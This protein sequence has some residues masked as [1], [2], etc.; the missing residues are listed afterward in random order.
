MNLR[1]LLV[2]FGSLLALDFTS[3]PASAWTMSIDELGNCTTTVG[4][5]SSQKIT[6]PS[7]PAKVA[8]PVEVWVYTLPSPVYSTD[9]NIVEPDGTVSDHLRTI[10]PADYAQPNSSTAS[11][12]QRD[13]MR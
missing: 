5:C 3:V 8:P 6:D 10:S 9:V 13:T 2:A 4:T 12:A 11:L 1:H 7:I